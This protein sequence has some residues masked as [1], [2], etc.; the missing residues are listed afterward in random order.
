MRHK[1]PV[2]CQKDGCRSKAMAVRKAQER[3]L[4]DAVGDQLSP[5][6]HHREEVQ[7]G[8]LILE[9]GIHGVCL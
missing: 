9:R 4:D 5:Q 3:R 6:D 7:E 8:C 1:L 2:T